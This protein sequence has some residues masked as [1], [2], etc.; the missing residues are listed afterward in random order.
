M[1][2]KSDPFPFHFPSP[3]P[4]KPSKVSQDKGGQELFALWNPTL[5]GKLIYQISNGTFSIKPNFMNIIKCQY[6][7]LPVLFWVA[8]GTWTGHFLQHEVHLSSLKEFVRSIDRLSFNNKNPGY[9]V[10]VS[11]S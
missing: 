3:S 7:F 5:A 1:V 6:M 9:L 10:Y 11:C 2:Y 8:S 4:A